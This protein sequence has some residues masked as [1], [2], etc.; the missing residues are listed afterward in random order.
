MPRTDR[1]LLGMALVAKERNGNLLLNVPPNR[2]GIIEPRYV[3]SL[4]ALRRN[5]DTLDSV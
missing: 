4:E 5:L 2:K 1:E 3:R